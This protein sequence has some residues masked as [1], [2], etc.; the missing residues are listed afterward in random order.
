[1]ERV[2]HLEERINGHVTEIPHP[3]VEVDGSWRGEDFQ[4]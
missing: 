4:I 3:H 1:M 2:E